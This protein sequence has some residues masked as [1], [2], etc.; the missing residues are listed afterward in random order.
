MA[1][2]I[3]WHEPSETDLEPSDLVATVD[4]PGHEWERRGARFEEVD[5]G[6]GEIVRS[7]AGTCETHAGRISF[8]IWDYGDEPL[9]YLL[10]SGELDERPSLA[11]LVVRQ[12][13]HEGILDPDVEVSMFANYGDIADPALMATAF[14]RA[15][16]LEPLGLMWPARATSERAAHVL[17]L[18][19]IQQMRRERRGAAMRGL[20]LVPITA[21]LAILVS[22]SSLFG[23][24]DLPAPFAIVLVG[25]VL[26]L[27]PLVI[28]TLLMAVRITFRVDAHPLARAW[29]EAFGHREG[30]S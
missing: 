7:A 26:V 3:I 21:L 9:T 14:A 6:D 22:A 18:Q 19:L 24:A 4:L 15:E 1:A 17:E 25:V 16:E 20:V 13:V 10:V 2:Q 12:M 29:R 30:D 28:V 8:R 5:D 23:E 27:V 11:H